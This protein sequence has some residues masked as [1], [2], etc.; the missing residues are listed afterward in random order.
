MKYCCTLLSIVQNKILKAEL[1]VVT[2]LDR[3]QLVSIEF[4]LF[5]EVFFLQAHSFYQD[6][7]RHFFFSVFQDLW[8]SKVGFKKNAG[9]VVRKVN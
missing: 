3:L 9:K 4:I 2:S 7:Y 6:F 1:R 5:L 8:A